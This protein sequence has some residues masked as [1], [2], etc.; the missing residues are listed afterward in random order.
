[1]RENFDMCV[2]RNILLLLA[3]VAGV[4]S[5]QK[6]D[7][8]NENKEAEKEVLSTVRILTR[9]ADQ[10]GLQYPLHVYAFSPNGSLISKKT[11]TEP[12]SLSLK[13]PMSSET[14]IVVVSADEE[15]YN[16]PENPN[17][18]SIITMKEPLLPED[19][20]GTTVKNATGYVTSHPLQMGIANIQPTMDKATANIQLNYRV[21]SVNI[22]LSNLPKECEATYVKIEK[23]IT[24]IGFDGKTAGEAK[25]H[26]PLYKDKDDTGRW[27]SGEVY[28]FP[29]VGSQTTFTIAYNDDNGEQFASANYLALLKA[30]TPYILNGTYADGTLDVS[31]VIEP[32]TWGEPV[33]LD[34]T[35][36][37]DTNTDI[38][39]DGSETGGGGEDDVYVVDEIPSQ[40]TLWEGHIVASV[41]DNKGF[42]TAS[43][44]LM[45]LIDYDG[46]HSAYSPTGSDEAMNIEEEY[47][48]GGLDGWRIP[49]EEEA[50]TLRNAY[51]ENT[52]AFDDIMEEEETQ[53]D[54]IILTDEKGKKQ[55]YLCSNAE[56]TYS[57][58]TGSSYNSI[59]N[60]GKTVTYRLRLVKTIT[61]KNKN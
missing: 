28:V 29:T 17:V 45:S 21:A 12:A 15:V 46:I 32:P 58:I 59:L 50:Q 11:L 47:M 1:M 16:I 53:A 41:S 24:G 4:Q 57:F 60:A 23:T 19:A 42:G 56:K 10:S 43:V 2:L 8:D 36:S 38:I 37:G 34:F 52:D 49:T 44:L 55:R 61:V 3:I 18:S 6:I 39:P 26:I 31:G 35:F 25:A 48:E 20:S 5:C 14:H 27:A 30:G 51:L 9:A 40:A 7:F 22:N 13:L 54:M 33:K